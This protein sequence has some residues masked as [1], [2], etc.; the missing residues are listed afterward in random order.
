MI[1]IKLEQVIILHLTN[2][3]PAVMGPEVQ[4]VSWTFNPSLNRFIPVNI[5]IIYIRSI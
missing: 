2:K 1:Q 5:V 4:H 3:F